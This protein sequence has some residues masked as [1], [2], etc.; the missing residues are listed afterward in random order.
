MNHQLF[1][2]HMAQFERIQAGR[3]KYQ[4]YCTCRPQMV[5]AG[6]ES[7]FIKW[8]SYGCKTHCQHTGINTFAREWRC[9]CGASSE[10]N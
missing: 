3:P 5:N 10:D 9:Q 7:M 2:E 1:D 8:D 6:T 4:T